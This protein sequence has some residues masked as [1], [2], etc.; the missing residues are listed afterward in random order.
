MK[1]QI[2]INPKYTITLLNLLTYA[3]FHIFDKIKK[4]YIFYNVSFF[5]LIKECL[6]FFFKKI[7]LVPNEKIIIHSFTP[8]QLIYQQNITG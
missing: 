1:N 8:C 2:I 5:F 6:I 4:L 7:A 3:F